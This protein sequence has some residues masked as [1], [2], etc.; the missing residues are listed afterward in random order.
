MSSMPRPIQNTIS[1][2]EFRQNLS[3]RARPDELLSL[4]VGMSDELHRDYCTRYITEGRTA[5]GDEKY[6]TRWYRH[7]ENRTRLINHRQPW[8]PTDHMTRQQIADRIFEEYLRQARVSA[9]RRFIERRASDIDRNP[10]NSDDPDKT[11]FVRGLP[12]DF[13]GISDPSLA[14]PDGFQINPGYF[15]DSYG[16]AIMA[17]FKFVETAVRRSSL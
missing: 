15:Y 16:S 5:R 13:D 9:M 2:T 7:H 11:P 6:E 4:H 8:V 10:P 17:K 1:Y 14:D 3:R 12:C